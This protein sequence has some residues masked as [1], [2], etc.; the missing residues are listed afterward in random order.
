MSS[1]PRI[2]FR[3]FEPVIMWL[4]LAFT[5]GS[6]V[7]GASTGIGRSLLELLLKNGEVVVATLRKAEVLADLSAKYPEDKLLVVRVDVSK[8][9][10]ITAAF[11]KTNEVFGHIDVV[12]NNAGYGSLGEAEATPNNVARAQ[13]EVNFW[14]ASN[15]SRAAVKFFREVNKPGVGGTLLQVSSI[16]FY[17][18][19]PALAYYSA[20]YV[21]IE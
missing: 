8:E 2:W 11:D 7:T 13:F 17:S 1:R 9:T 21:F 15:V 19:G 14:G 5:D 6:L 16:V 10:D 12:F 4:T 18:P 3:T 20:R